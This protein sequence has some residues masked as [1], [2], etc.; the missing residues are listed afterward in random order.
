[1]ALFFLQSVWQIPG[2]NL[3]WLEMTIIGALMSIANSNSAPQRRSA[4]VP[5]IIASVFSVPMLG[6]AALVTAGEAN[7][8]SLRISY[9]GMVGVAVLWLL[10]R[11][12]EEDEVDRAHAA[13]RAWALRITPWLCLVPFITVASL[14]LQTMAVIPEAQP[15]AVAELTL[16]LSWTLV[17]M[18]YFT[19]CGIAQFFM[20]SDS[21][22]PRAVCGDADEGGTPPP[23]CTLKTDCIG[24]VV[25][26]M[27][28][29]LHSAVVLLILIGLFI[30]AN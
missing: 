22:A 26:A 28:Q 1:M 16:V 17:L 6:I 14:R 24:C 23:R 9:V 11:L 12:S 27:H 2:N 3:I 8:I 19:A 21:E 10:E 7:V 18:L 30:N 5:L 20:D 13:E 4:D 25:Y 29:L 15:W